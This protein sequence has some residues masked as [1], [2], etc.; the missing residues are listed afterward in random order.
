MIVIVVLP[1]HKVFPNFPP[2]IL[3]LRLDTIKKTMR[4]KETCLKKSAIWEQVQR[5]GFI[6]LEM[7][8]KQ[9]DHPDIAIFG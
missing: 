1:C 7:A 5:S 6:H 9:S 4:A 3:A 2:L 8:A